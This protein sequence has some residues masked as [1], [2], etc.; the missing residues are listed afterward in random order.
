MSARS[1]R[2][3]CDSLKRSVS[4]VGH[5]LAGECRHGIGA[6]CQPVQPPCNPR[7]E[8]HSPITGK[9]ANACTQWLVDA[10]SNLKSLTYVIAI[11]DNAGDGPWAAA[12]A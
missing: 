5:G 10:Y 6:H 12:T 7:M 9:E 3:G 2:V 4:H 1:F 8:R 11:A